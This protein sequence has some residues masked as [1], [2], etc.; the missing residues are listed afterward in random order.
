MR[1]LHCTVCVCVW[2]VMFV[3]KLNRYVFKITWY[4]TKL[5]SPLNTLDNWHQIYSQTW[6]LTTN[7]HRF[8]SA[9][10]QLLRWSPW[11]TEALYD[12]SL[13]LKLTIKHW[14]TYWCY[15]FSIIHQNS[16]HL[17][18]T[19]MPVCIFCCHDNCACEPVVV[20]FVDH[21]FQISIEI[22]NLIS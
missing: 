10:T 11:F 12:L 19:M 16:V 13:K 17:Q 9:Q 21:T 7:M 6:R 22:L 2:G 8:L 3:L 14:H 20:C 5:T 4:T 15:F 1:I 18:N